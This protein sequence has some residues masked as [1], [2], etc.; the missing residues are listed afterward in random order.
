MSKHIDLKGV[1]TRIK[2][3]YSSDDSAFE[4]FVRNASRL[5]V[6]NADSRRRMIDLR[7][8]KTP[9]TKVSKYLN[10][11]DFG[12]DG[13]R[14]DVVYLIQEK[15]GISFPEAVKKLA[16]WENENI[17]EE[18]DFK[19][20]PIEK[21]EEVQPYKTIYIQKRKK[22][23]LVS[24]NRSL[25][26][27]L[28]EGLCRSCSIEEM[29]M[30]V[31]LFDIGLT[32]YNDRETN[33]VVYRLFIPE[34][35]YNK[36]P[37]G[38]FK[39]NRGLEVKGLLRS[40]SKRVLFGSHLFPLFDPLKP[41]IFTEGHSD[42]IV[43]NAKRMASVTSGSSTTKI[44]EEGLKLLAGRKIH[45]YPDC[46]EA[47]LKGICMKIIQIEEFNATQEEDMQIDYRVFWWSK[48]YIESKTGK[49]ITMKELV[50]KQIDFFKSHD[51]HAPE[52]ARVRNWKVFPLSK[53][54]QGFD[55]I[56]FHNEFKDKEGYDIFKQKYAF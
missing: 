37:Y 6:L 2:S 39:Y 46:D 54:K 25:F 55:F 30:A 17:E 29:R 22:E 33:E 21:K 9:S 44:P 45:F 16:E 48:S 32:H 31:K 51:F 50:K 49:E 5:G 52:Q 38:A 26:K 47:G 35:D 4:F 40:N 15:E 1:L 13:R 42:C 7:G 10:Y 36:T 43:N 19:P 12:A 8:E 11:C 3:K 24:S 28:I 53:V 20:L 18:V 34:Y 23:S 14:H 27:S 56:D 41:I